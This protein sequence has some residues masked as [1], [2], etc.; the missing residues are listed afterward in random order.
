M[1][2]FV[3]Y[4]R[5]LNHANEASN[6]LF[7]HIKLLITL[8][9]SEGWA[10]VTKE[11]I[12]YR[13]D[14][15]PVIH[16]RPRFIPNDVLE[17]LN[18][19]IDKLPTNIMSIVL[20]LLHT[21]RRIGE[22]CALQFDCLRQDADGDYLL[23]YYEFKMKKEETIP[24]NKQAVSVI[25]KQQEWLRKSWPKLKLKYLF[26]D[27]SQLP[28]EADRVRIALKNLAKKYKI[29]GP[30]GNVWSFQPHQ[31]R[32]TVG[33]RMINAGVPVPIVQKFLRHA[34][35]EM[36]MRYAHIF[37]STMKAEFEKFQDKLVDITGNVTDCQSNLP[38]DLKWLKH[39]ILAQSLP[40]G[41]CALPV[42]LGS[43]PHSNACLTCCHFRTSGCFLTIHKKQLIETKRI[44]KVAQKNGWDRQIEVNQR[45]I[46]N[47][48]II[49]DTLE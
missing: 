26:P 22:I 7:T 37:D 30:D 9:G 32:H 42:S 14:R 39:N 11:R 6:K 12:M 3:G 31:F 2:G 28:I 25:L 38:T 19:H 4:V 46:N 29:L 21:G 17:Q 8:A 15:F 20:L 1:L 45:I 41:L 24:L 13:E 33:T 18:I 5:K 48:S 43:C 34:S 40:N 35:P 10:N 49:I 36:T 23:L 16:A 44:L 47:L 27:G